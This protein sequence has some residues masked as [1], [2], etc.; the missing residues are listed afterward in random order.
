MDRREFLA[1]SAAAGAFAIPHALR[2]AEGGAKP[3]AKSE[4]EEPQ[5]RVTLSEADASPLS[6]ERATTLCAR[7]LAND[8][9]PQHIAHAEDRARVSLAA[10]PIELSLR[11]DVPGFGEVYCWAD[12]GGKGY[13]KPGTINFA[14]D[15]AATRLRRVRE[16][17]DLAK[18]ESA[19]IDPKT[20]KHLKDAGQRVTDVRTAYAALAAGLHAGEQISLACARN[21]ISRFEKPRNDFLFGG[22]ISGYADLGPKYEKAI[23]DRF[24]F[25]TV[26]WYTWKNE[27]PVDQRIDYG[28]MDSSIKWCLDRHITPKGF[29]YCYMTRGATPE[30]IRTW[31][32]EKILPEYVRVVTQTMK[33][34]SGKLPYAEIINE[35]HDKSNL[36]RLSQPQILEITRAVC[37]AARQGSPTVKRQINNCCLWAEYARTPNKDGSRRWSPYRYIS[38]CVSSGTDFDVVG[39]QLYYPQIDVLEIE[40]MLDRF[41]KFNKPIHI[42][43]IATASVDGP[44]PNSMRPKT[45]APGWHGPWSEPTQA[46]WLEAIYTLIYSKPEFEAIGWWDLT[47]RPGHFWPHGGLLHADLSPKLAYHRLGELQRA[48]GVSRPV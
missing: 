18:S 24:N 19:T 41:K 5:L 9:L 25:A 14:V 42:T 12:N 1:A 29:G 15:A 21:R 44:D 23:R 47:D 43:E 20:E 30:W 26:T 45:T 48:W 4:R 6:K 36:W 33:R 28:R 8:P 16:A 11:L 2:A 38:D 7:D 31:P 40:R 27:Q 3:K 22:M 34:Y 37:Q 46:D 13:T 17:Y 32:F 10:E 35:A 39:L